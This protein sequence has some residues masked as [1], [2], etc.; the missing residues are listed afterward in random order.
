MKAWTA[1]AAAIATIILAGAVEAQ[2]RTK[3]KAP[4]PA[5]TAPV[6]PVVDP[7]PPAEPLAQAVKAYASYQNEINDL[8]GATLANADDLERALDRAAGV[9]RAALTRGWIA[10]GAMTA[11]QAPEF[12]RGV[13]DTATHY[14]RDVMIRGLTL[15]PAYA[16]RLKGGAEAA[17]LAMMSARADGLRVYSVGERYKEMAYSLQSQRWANQIAPAQPARV[18]RMRTLAA[19]ASTRDVPAEFAPRLVVPAGSLTPWTDPNQFGG[20]T[21]WDNFRLAQAPPIAAPLPAPVLQAHHDRVSTINRMT[22]LAALYVMDATLDPAAQAD[23][24]LN[25][26]STERC[27]EL[28]QVQ[29]Y[30]CMSAARFRYENA[31]CLGEHALKEMGSCIR[32]AT[33]EAPMTPIVAELPPAPVAPVE[34]APSRRKKR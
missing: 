32:N 27:L 1:F 11:A 3:A 10:Y 12:V 14:G 4:Q 9:N 15:D 6:A 23:R 24:M 5:V 13:R 26:G 18:T 25:E 29:F 8:Q 22:T 33:V 34:P 19:G 28:A 17:R 2:P 7:G 31:F 20:A 16:E 30:Q 21:F